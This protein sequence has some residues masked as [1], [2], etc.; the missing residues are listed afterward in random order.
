MWFNGFGFWLFFSLVGLLYAFLGHTARNRLLVVAS[1]A[2]YAC[3]DWK[4]SW[5]ILLCISLNF[6]TAWQIDSS[7]DPALRRRW[8]ITGVSI[9]LA[10][11]ATL[12]I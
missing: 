11:L 8:L 10:V 6:V 5:L 4:F 9:S 2:F 1:F 12:N 7:A 3:I